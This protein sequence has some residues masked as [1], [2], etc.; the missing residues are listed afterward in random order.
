[1]SSRVKSTIEWQGIQ[2]GGDS[3]WIHI[4]ADRT[5]RVIISP[6]DSGSLVILVKVIINTSGSG[7]ATLLTDTA[8][9]VI[10]SLAAAA[11]PGQYPY[12]LPCADGGS[13]WID[14][15]GAADITVVYK[16]R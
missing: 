3:Q 7:S 8:T 15:A 16:N 1:M 11:T 14:N 13:L 12:N 9:G 4:G 10:A 2:V 6:R 5:S